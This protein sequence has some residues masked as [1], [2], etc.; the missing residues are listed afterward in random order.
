MALYNTVFGKG[1]TLKATPY[2]IIFGKKAKPQATPYDIIFSNDPKPQ[3]QPQQQQ[4]VARTIPK[5]ETPGTGANRGA[6]GNLGTS[7]GAGVAGNAQAGLLG[8]VNTEVQ[9]DDQLLPYQKV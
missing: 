5:V 8:S 9:N 2:D 4:Q 3:Q 1:P 7:S 6:V